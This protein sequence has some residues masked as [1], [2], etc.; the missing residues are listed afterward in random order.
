MYSIKKVKNQHPDFILFCIVLILSLFGL[1]MVYS[2]SAILASVDY[3]TSFYFFI[4]QFIFL[5]IGGIGLIVASKINLSLARSWAF[6]G[7]LVGLGLMVLVC[8]PGIGRS[9]GGAQRWFRLGLFSFQPSE[10]MKILLI[11]YLA[12]S[13]DRRQKILNQFSGIIPYLMI[14]GSILILLELQHDFGNAL[15]LAFLTLTMLLLAGVPW[16]SF[17]I[18]AASLI[19]V[20]VYFVLAQRYRVKRI[21]AF[22][23]PWKYASSTGFQLVQSLIAVGSG[24]PLGVGLSNSNQKLFYLPAPHTDFIFA[25]ICEELGLIG[26]IGVSVLFFIFMIRGFKIAEMASQKGENIF[27]GLL[28]V[29]LTSSIGFQAFSNFGVVIGL[30]PTKGITLPLI[31]YGGSSLVFT[32]ISIGLLLNISRGLNL[33][34]VFENKDRELRSQYQTWKAE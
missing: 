33:P 30:L 34:S 4:R 31:S 12:D 23:H 21:I 29:G 7:L 11:F 3:G 13:L 24:G 2:A 16:K 10:A 25:I 26:S 18:P 9:I 28:A 17:L 5:V 20:F 27:Y 14:L 1:I 15:L 22:L 32:L 8:I 19:P 6:K